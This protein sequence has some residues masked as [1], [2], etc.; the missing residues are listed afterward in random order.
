MIRKS[1]LCLP[2]A[3]FQAPGKHR[4]KDIAMSGPSIPPLLP[5]FFKLFFL[6]FFFFNVD[7]F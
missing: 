4:S 7:H 6:S 5:L 3:L 1:L 2:R